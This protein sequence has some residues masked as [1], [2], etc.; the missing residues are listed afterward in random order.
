[1]QWWFADTWTER[2][3]PS[4]WKSEEGQ[5]GKFEHTA[6]DWYGHPEADKGIKTTPDARF[7]TIWTEMEE[8]FLNKDKDLVLQVCSRRLL[9]LLQEYSHLNGSQCPS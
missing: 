3:Q 5:A 6:G 7:Y 1:M 2:W 8:E 4:T 9:L